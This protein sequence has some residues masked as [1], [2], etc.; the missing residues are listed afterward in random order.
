MLFT[1]VRETTPDVRVVNLNGS[2]PEL[3]P[4]FVA[5]AHA[6]VSRVLYSKINLITIYK[7]VKAK[8]SIGGWTGSLFWS[9]NVATAQNRFVLVRYARVV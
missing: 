4:R 8:V 3:L 1:S 7:G 2:D 9:S 6:H 5:A